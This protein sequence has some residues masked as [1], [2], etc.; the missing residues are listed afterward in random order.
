MI[1]AVIKEMARQ[2]QELYGSVVFVPVFG[3]DAM[4]HRVEAFFRW[5]DS[6]SYVA[7]RLFLFYVAYHF[8]VKFW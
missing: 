3:N 6:L 5:V 2:L 7:L 8:L 4:E 1:G